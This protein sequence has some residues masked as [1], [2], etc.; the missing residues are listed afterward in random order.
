MTKME[1]LM[2]VIALAGSKVA[3]AACGYPHMPDG[4]SPSAVRDMC[5]FSTRRS[6]PAF[7]ALAGVMMARGKKEAI[8]A[9]LSAV[10]L[11][12]R[13]GDKWE[14]QE[15]MVR[16]ACDGGGILLHSVGL[17]D[18]LQREGKNRRTSWLCLSGGRIRMVLVCTGAKGNVKCLGTATYVGSLQGPPDGP[19]VFIS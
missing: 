19:G 6:R 9:L 10:S 2:R 14:T 1:A 18:V 3:M 12:A 17:E 5:S 15:L 4:I 11:S 8:R 13:M 16:E 7:A